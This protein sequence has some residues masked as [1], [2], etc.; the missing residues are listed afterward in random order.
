MENLKQLTSRITADFLPVAVKQNNFFVND[1]PANLPIEY[2]HEWIS[3]IINGLVSTIVHHARNT[4]IR[5]SAKRFGYVMVLEIQESGSANGYAM[6]CSLQE[7][8]SQAQQ[9]G[10]CLNISIPKPELTTVAFS[11]P[12]LPFAA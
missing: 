12:N 11:F 5:F 1:I 2:N 3:S 10:G 6:A 9:I 8:Q 7:V 4:C